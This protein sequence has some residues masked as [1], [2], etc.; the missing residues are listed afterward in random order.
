VD[1]SLDIQNFEPIAGPHGIFSVES[2][3]VLGHLD[4][5]GGLV[6]NYAKDPL[7]LVPAAGDEVSLVE[8]QMVGD[9][10]FAIG[11]YDRVELDLGFPVYFINNAELNQ[12]TLDGATIG[13]LRVRP[14]LNILNAAQHGLGLGVYLNLALPTGDNAA[15]TSSGSFS[16]RPGA[17]LDAKAGPILLAF[18]LAANIE[19]EQQFGN[20]N[21]G[22]GLAWGAGAQYDI[23]GDQLAVAGEIFGST[24]FSDFMSVKEETPVEGLLGLKS[25]SSYGLGGQLAG[26]AGIVPGYGSPLYRIVVG[27]SYAQVGNDR[28][29]DGIRDSVDGCPDDPEDKD[30]FE[31]EDGCPDLDNDQDGILDKADGCPN[32]PEDIDTFED[33]DGCPDPDNDGDT[34]LDVNDDCPL[35]PGPPELRGCPDDDPDG[36]GIPNSSDA[37]PNDPEDIDGFEDEDGCPDTDNDKDGILDGSDTCPDDPEDIDGFEDEDGCPDVDNDKDGIPDVEDKCPLVKGTRKWEGCPGKQMVVLTGSEIKILEQVYFDTGKTTIKKRSYDLL[38]QVAN[39][40]LSTPV[41]KKVEVQGHTDDRGGDDYNLKLS[42]GRAKSVR[43]YLVGRG[44]AA[45]RLESRGYGEAQPAVDIK[46]LRGGKLNQART[47]NRRVQF[48][49]IEQER[50]RKM[51]EVA[52]DAE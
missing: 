39:V 47:D 38:N 35:V 10:L 30:G 32:D 14:K 15:F 18:N 12:Q 25:R 19:K 9:V 34:V 28:D 11:L 23:K 22:S 3:E 1:P 49:I 16:A 6:V 31:D 41:L 27:L 8:Q 13:D 37:C 36:D 20:I 48:K 21:A 46:G 52:P 7:V 4:I 5:A 42:D 29:G 44:V 50:E 33:E 45:D 26:G 17:V 24:T 40:L 2:A 51:I 43:D